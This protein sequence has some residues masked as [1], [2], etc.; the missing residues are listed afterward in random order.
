MSTYVQATFL[1]TA[2]FAYLLLTA[3]HYYYAPRLSRRSP[4]A[5]PFFYRPTNT[6]W[7]TVFVSLFLLYA[8]VLASSMYVFYVLLSRFDRPVFVTL[9]TSKVAISMLMGLLVGVFFYVTVFGADTRLRYRAFLPA[10]LLF[11]FV[12]FFLMMSKA[13]Y[14]AYFPSRR[15]HSVLPFL[16]R[17]V[18]RRPPR[19]RRFLARMVAIWEPRFW[20]RQP[21]LR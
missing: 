10:T 7:R 1:L 9:L 6:W 11:F 12:G 17:T 16:R 4:R 18:T 21:I 20:R 8:A 15:P 5:F 19:L 3:L 2:A 13:S 14:L